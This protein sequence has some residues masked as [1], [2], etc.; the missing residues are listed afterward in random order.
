MR[1][2]SEILTGS[3]QPVNRT[4]QSE[5]VRATQAAK[6]ADSPFQVQLSNLME[7]ANSVAPSSGEIR[8]EKVDSVRNQLAAGS[9]NI[10]GN[11][12]ALKMLSLLGS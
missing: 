2:D 1:I 4:K 9:Y 3:L 12:V 11:D 6:A 10:S 7:K 8:Q 5:R